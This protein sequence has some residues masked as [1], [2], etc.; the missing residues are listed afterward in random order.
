VSSAIE[1]DDWYILQ[2]AIKNTGMT[3]TETTQAYTKFL[4]A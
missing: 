1:A 3:T 4:E 2:E